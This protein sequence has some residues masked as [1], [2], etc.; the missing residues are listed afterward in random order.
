MSVSDGIYCRIQDQM[1]CCPEWNQNNSPPFTL[2]AKT[3][4]L[5][6][7]NYVNY[8]WHCNNLVDSP[9]LPSTVHSEILKPCGIFGLHSFFFRLQ[10]VC[11]SKVLWQGQGEPLQGPSSVMSGTTLSNSEVLYIINQLQFVALLYFHWI[12]PYIDSVYKSWC[13]WVCI[14][15]PLP[16]NLFQR[17]SVAGF[18]AST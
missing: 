9:A 4:L 17:S 18:I 3:D 11:I 15:V 13:L 10:P 12:G 1:K 7:F 16:C 5:I 6:P 2:T 8:F 14:F